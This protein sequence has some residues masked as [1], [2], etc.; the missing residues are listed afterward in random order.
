MEGIR[1]SAGVRVP[2]V[3]QHLPDVRQ[4]CAW[5]VRPP[6]NHPFSGGAESLQGVKTVEPIYTVSLFFFQNIS[7]DG[8]RLHSFFTHSNSTNL[9]LEDDI[10]VPYIRMYVWHYTYSLQNLE[11]P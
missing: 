1:V 8:K 9:Q 10:H 5:G 6:K 2:A 11:H 4:E 7:K 3:P